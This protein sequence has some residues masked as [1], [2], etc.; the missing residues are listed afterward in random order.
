MDII[1]LKYLENHSKYI[2]ESL[3]KNLMQSMKQKIKTKNVKVL[4]RNIP[5]LVYHNHI[6]G[7]TKHDCPAC[8]IVGINS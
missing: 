3:H 5:D 6:P 2:K 8:H 7:C 1:I 4:Q